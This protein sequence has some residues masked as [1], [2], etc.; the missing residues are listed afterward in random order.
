MYH[1]PYGPGFYPATGYVRPPYYQHGY[2]N[3][4]IIINQNNNYW[5]HVERG[6]APINRRNARSPI[7][8]AKPNRPELASLNREAND[9]ARSKSRDGVRDEGRDAGKAGLDRPGQKGYAGA[10]PEGKAERERLVQNAKAS[11]RDASRLDGNAA[12]RDQASRS[13]AADAKNRQ[14]SKEGSFAGPAKR[15][16]PK[17]GAVADRGHQAEGTGAA[18]SNRSATH[19]D[20]TASSQGDRAASTGE[21]TAP[22][23]GSGTGASSGERRTASQTSASSH[24]KDRSAFDS[25][26]KSG[27]SEQA[28]SK[29]GSA[30]RKGGHSR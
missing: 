26:G 1:P 24:S 17:S 14:G 15:D 21:R 8:Q 20:R 23:H 9:R 10:R 29:R 2:N 7:T 19:G 11:G 5:N 25:G 30:S 16:S 13:P 12:T 22:S 3:N 4:T 28:A 18:A 6:S 27:H